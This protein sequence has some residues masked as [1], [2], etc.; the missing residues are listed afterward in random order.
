MRQSSWASIRNLRFG[1][2]L[3]AAACY[4]R[5]EELNERRMRELKSAQLGIHRQMKNAEAEI[6]RLKRKTREET[7]AF[8]RTRAAGIQPLPGSTFSRRA[9]IPMLTRRPSREL[10]MEAPRGGHICRIRR[11]RRQPCLPPKPP[12]G[13]PPGPPPWPPI[14]PMPPIIWLVTV[15]VSSPLTMRVPPV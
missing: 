9:M 12:P 14:W 2:Y 13:P 1:E 15:S 4:R 8:C 7:G 6:A 10:P 3:R 11:L 5:R